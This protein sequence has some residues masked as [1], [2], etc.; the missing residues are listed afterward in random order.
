MA[1]GHTPTAL[2]P[3]R[4]WKNRR[5]G[6]GEVVLGILGR[7]EASEVNMGLKFCISTYERT[8]R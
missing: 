3:G 5:K 4:C 1:P 7:E 2:S 8:A 6:R